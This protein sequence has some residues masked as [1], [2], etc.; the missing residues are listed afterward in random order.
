MEQI[1]HVVND[2][3]LRGHRDVILGK[4]FLMDNQIVMDFGSQTVYDTPVDIIEQDSALVISRFST[5]NTVVGESTE[6][7]NS[8][9]NL[10]VFVVNH[11]LANM[12]FRGNIIKSIAYG[13]SAGENL[14]NLVKNCD[15]A[16]WNEI[17]KSDYVISMG[18]RDGK[19]YLPTEILESLYDSAIL[20]EE[21]F[22]FKEEMLKQ[23]NN[24]ASNDFI[25]EFL[26]NLNN[27][28]SNFIHEIEKGGKNNFENIFKLSS[29]SDA[30]DSL[31]EPNES[32]CLSLKNVN[33]DNSVKSE[34]GSEVN[35]HDKESKEITSGG[36]NRNIV[37]FLCDLCKYI[38]KF[39]NQVNI[40][41]NLRVIQSSM[42]DLN[43]SLIKLK[44]YVF[45]SG[46]VE[47]MNSILKLMGKITFNSND[48]LN[49]NNILYVDIIEFLENLELELVLLL[50]V[51]TG[52][53]GKQEITYDFS[54]SNKFINEICSIYNMKKFITIPAR[55]ERI[56]S[57]ILDSNEEQICLSRE[58]EK[59]VYAANCIIRPNAH[60]V[61]AISI[62]NTTNK[63]VHLKEINLEIRFL[64]NYNVLSLTSDENIGETERTKKLLEKIKV[65]HLNKEEVFSLMEILNKY[66]HI[67]H[68]EG[69]KLTYT[70][71]VMHRIPLVE[72]SKIV[73]IKPYRL[74]LSQREEIKKQTEQML[75]DKVIRRSKSEYSSPLLVIPKKSTTDE[76]KFRVV[77]DFRELNSI[78][79]GDC[80]PIQNISEI[81]D[82]LGKSTYFS[83]LD[84][85][86]GYHQI[87][88]HP[89]DRH[90]TAFSAGSLGLFEF[91]RLP[92]GLKNA[93]ATFARLMTVA[94]SG[95]QGISCLV[96]LDDI[97]VFGHNLREHNERLIQVFERL[98]QHNLKLQP[99]KCRFL[100]REVIYLG[101]LISDKGV[102]P[103]PTKTDAVRNW[104]RPM[105]AK[106]IKS[107]MGTVGYFRRFID[108]F[109]DIA[110]PLTS[111]L[112][113][114]VKF[115]WNEKC[116]A[117]FNELKNKLISAPILQYI[118]FDK[119]LFLKTDA[120]GTGISAILTQGTLDN[121][122]PVAFISRTLQDAETR[123]SATE[124]EML[125]I[126]W[127]I[128]QLRHYLLSKFFTVIT[129]CKSLQGI[130]K[131]KDSFNRLYRMR[132]Q[133]ADYNFIV[134]Y[135]P[136][137]T[138]IAD[139]LS[140][141]RPTETPK[142]EVAA[143]TR[144]GKDTMSNQ[145]Q[146]FEDCLKYIN[147]HYDY[148]SEVVEQSLFKRNAA[149]I[150]N[151]IQFKNLSFNE[152][153]I[154]IIKNINAHI[155]IARKIGDGSYSFLLLS[156]DLTYENVF[157]LLQ[158][159]KFLLYK[160][161]IKTINF[162]RD[163]T[164]CDK[165]EYVKLKQI[166]RYVF[167]HSE[168]TVTIYLDDITVLS[169]KT[170]IDRL[171][172]EY[173]DSLIGGHSGARRTIKRI[174]Q[175]IGHTLNVM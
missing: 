167:K 94:M 26:G 22:N 84:L 74:P 129:D 61:G 58:V 32:Q 69:D 36:N 131:M 24:T 75:K 77:V 155:K 143:I 80:F 71:T 130:F 154:E 156:D 68:L 97:V 34:A 29:I 19:L 16:L 115:Q 47:C 139:G 56:V 102:S 159:L 23:K 170:D 128:K 41:T 7:N 63:D 99:E 172:H 107:F 147:E 60:N 142:N 73:H 57:I 1:F 164:I 20:S 96:Y 14:D 137:K 162:I 165:L 31:Q 160:Y 86:S 141:L 59:G 140:R 54:K 105:N 28:S 5:P 132:L 78:S 124:R 50:R 72:N 27:K 127:A 39:L 122:L 12:N 83:T 90:L 173:H 17:V 123:Y 112:K 145:K 104:P 85:A 144:T 175:H 148:S 62:L 101:H 150:K 93:P 64:N 65:N 174:K 46:N 95:L 126:Y 117:A 108:K 40:G 8:N 51:F 49:E 133:L 118:N 87:L 52:V 48:L 30:K 11:G 100:R 6:N 149:S 158:E 70:T 33:F 38:R 163:K 136:G 121:D 89:K 53:E 88:V 120:S 114:D 157:H 92:F 45:Y 171:I 15:S 13:I 161:K 66:N 81:L 146:S 43:D 135:K 98:E 152:N 82:S 113:K 153:N 76:K 2:Q 116:E 169:D 10:S 79:I 91:N 18:F 55:T 37:E 138:N 125:A 134:I 151:Q 168:I 25:R 103:D 110:K 119:N 4:D 166:F 44:K 106:D 67:F 42:N 9:L 3:L 111:L 109:S 21:N 35:G